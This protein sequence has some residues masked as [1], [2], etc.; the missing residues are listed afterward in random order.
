[1]LLTKLVARKVSGYALREGDEGGFGL[2]GR[3]QLVVVTTEAHTKQLDLESLQNLLHTAERNTLLMRIG[4]GECCSQTAGEYL[5][6]GAVPNLSTRI[7]R[8]S[9]VQWSE[10]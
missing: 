10:A 5:P 4:W 6:A 7:L 3:Q 8:L 9:C 2:K 1:M